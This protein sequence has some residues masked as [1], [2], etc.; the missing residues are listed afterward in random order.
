MRLQ[1]V[2]LFLTRTFCTVYDMSTLSW[3]ILF[4]EGFQDYFPSKLVGS[5]THSALVKP[6]SLGRGGKD[7]YGA[8]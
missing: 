1:V 4:V 3:L 8:L 7:K 5:I 6:A 2:Q